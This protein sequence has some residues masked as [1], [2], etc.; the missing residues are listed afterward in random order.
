[1]HWSEGFV[2]PFGHLS[3]I[4]QAI[5]V[6]AGQSDRA[7]VLTAFLNSRIAVWYA[8]HGTAS[9]GSDRPEVTLYD[10]AKARSCSVS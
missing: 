5:V 7:K 3:D 4:L 6:P 2:R 9:F 10:L 1:M 8:F